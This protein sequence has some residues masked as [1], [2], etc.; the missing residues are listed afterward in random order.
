MLVEYD[1]DE[2]YRDSLKI[3]ADIEKDQFAQKNDMRLVRMPY[4]VQLDNLTLH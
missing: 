1:G 3:K 4:W 2:H